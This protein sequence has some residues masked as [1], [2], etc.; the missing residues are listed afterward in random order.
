MDNNKKML[1]MWFSAIHEQINLIESQVRNMDIASPSNI[2]Y[3]D[4][5]YTLD[6]QFDNINLIKKI[7]TKDVFLRGYNHSLINRV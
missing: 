7:I 1:D 6:N 5:I 2:N 4:I 3:N